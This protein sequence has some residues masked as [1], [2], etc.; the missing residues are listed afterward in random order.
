MEM[1][2]KIENDFKNALKEKDTVT[3]STL[4]MVK[5]A[6]H[7]KEIEKRG[8]K[9]QEAEVVKIITKQ[10]QQ[11]QD[12]IEQFKKGGREDLVE[13]ETKE[14]EILKRYLPPQLSAQEI[15]AIVKKIIAEVGA[16]G[17]ADFGKVM[18]QVMAELKGKADGKV[19][20]QIVS[21]LLKP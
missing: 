3:V 1:A 9:L 14:L 5:A 12:S 7:N 11:H 10:V 17:K 21:D 6:I 8:E 18:K 13:K 15:T 20:N 16:Q 4:R 19:V 2:K